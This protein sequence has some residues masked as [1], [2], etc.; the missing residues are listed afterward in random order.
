MKAEIARTIISLASLVGCQQGKE[1]SVLGKYGANHIT[2]LDDNMCERL[3]AHY[4]YIKGED[5]DES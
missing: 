4:E 2:I 5:R 1:Y 3:L